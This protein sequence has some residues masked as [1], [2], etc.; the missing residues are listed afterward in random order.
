MVFQ[1]PHERLSTVLKLYDED[2]LDEAY[3][4]IEQ[5]L[6]IFHSTTSVRV[7]YIDLLNM[8]AYIL[9]QRQQKL[10]TIKVY[11]EMIASI[12]PIAHL[13]APYHML[14]ETYPQTLLRLGFAYADQGRN[15]DADEQFAAAEKIWSPGSPED[16]VTKLYRAEVL[17]KSGPAQDIKTANRLFQAVIE[18]FQNI[19][20]NEIAP[21]LKRAREGQQRTAA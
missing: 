11:E 6:P 20:D 21:Y 7:E 4:L 13:G 5:L 16:A 17:E 3:T 1:D 10:E 8:K 14:N 18:I 2:K 12:K 19:E 9:T 15:A